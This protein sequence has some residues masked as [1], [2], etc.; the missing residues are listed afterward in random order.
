MV[1]FGYRGDLSTDKGTA[2]DGCGEE[3]EGGARREEHELF[4]GAR[5]ESIVAGGAEALEESMCAI[6]GHVD[7]VLGRAGLH[8][9]LAFVESSQLMS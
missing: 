1:E 7:E 5:G 6:G 2:R 4:P 9:R 8:G 3:E